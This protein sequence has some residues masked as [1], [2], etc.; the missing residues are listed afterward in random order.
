MSVSKTGINSPDEVSFLSRLREY[1]RCRRYERT[2][3]N[4]GPDA[5]EEDYRRMAE[6]WLKYHRVE[7]VEHRHREFIC[8]VWWGWIE[9]YSRSVYPDDPVRAE[10]K[11]LRG[12]W[13][14]PAKSG[15]RR[16]GARYGLVGPTDYMRRQRRLFKTVVSI[17]LERERLSQ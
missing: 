3:W 15:R 9:G 5:T 1:W 12:L 7:L 17:L 13:R 8:R 11:F 4:P 14:C 16:P 6:L 2:R 10:Q